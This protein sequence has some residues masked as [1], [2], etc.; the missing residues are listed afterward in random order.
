V[1]ATRLFVV[2]AVVVLGA[3][4]FAAG[5]QACS[6]AQ[7]SPKQALRGADAAI[8]GE[9]VAVI[10]RGDLRADYRY[11]VQRVYKKRVGIRRG[12]TI[13]VRSATA[14]SACGLPRRTGRRYGVLL[15]WSEGHWTSGLCGV[16][17]PD[18]LHRLC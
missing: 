14:S 12:R 3:L 7:T 1:G 9:L 5:A 2:A 10:P 11:R 15:A 13:S 18:L 8:V 4:A 6:C 17:K 16:M